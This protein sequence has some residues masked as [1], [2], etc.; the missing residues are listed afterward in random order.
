MLASRQ[1]SVIRFG[2]FEANLHSGEL[3]EQGRT[4]RVQPQ[5]MKVLAVLLERPG[6]LVTRD[7][8]RSQLWPDELYV[9]FERGLNRSINKL[10]Y[11]L[12]DNADAP[13]YIETITKRGYRFIAPVLVESERD[14]GSRPVPSVAQLAEVPTGPHWR[15]RLILWSAFAAIPVLLLISAW[16]PYHRPAAA[17]SVNHALKPVPLVTFGNGEQ[18]LP[19]F[20]PDGTRIAY[21][22]STSTGWY[23]EIKDVSLDTHARLTQR[24]ATFPPGPTWSPDGRQ[25]AFARAGVAD[26]RGVFVIS[27]IGG[28]ERKLRT[29]APWWVPERV[30]SW[31]PD[32]RWIAFADE[33]RADSDAKLNRRGPNAIYL[34]S[35]NTLETRQLTEPLSGDYGDSAPTFSPDGT[36]IAFVRTKSTSHDEI[37]TVPVNGGPP[38]LLVTTGLWT[39]GL[40]WTPD[41]KSIIFDRS[42]AGGF[43]LWRI[44]SSGSNMHPLDVPCEFTCLEPTLWGDHLA[45]ES[46]IWERT[47][48]RVA[49][50]RSHSDSAVTPYTSTRHEW[51]GRYSPDG[52][53]IAFISDRTGNDELWM[54]DAEGS[55]PIQLTG[56]NTPL[57]DLSWNS[58]GNSIAVSA[59]SGKVFLVS[60][61]THSVRLLFS[62]QPFTDEGART[63]AFSR[64]GNFF[65]VLSEPGTGESYDLL[66][67]SLADGLASKVAEGKIWN[68]AET[69][70][71]KTLF[72]SRT[73]GLW[74]RP[75]EEGAE[76]LVAPP[77]IGPWDIG[78]DGLYLLT[79]GAIERF[80]F[81]GTRRE[82]VAKLPQFSPHSPLSISPGGTAALVG[83]TQRQTVEIDVVQGFQ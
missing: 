60:V 43:R 36:T 23:L 39:N 59:Y 30:V 25:I 26:D 62:G 81:D 37:Y 32:G 78:P 11:A 61:A 40:T 46:H 28:P 52:Q 58:T 2:P 42:Q 83:Y 65:Y 13:A 12:L 44:S 73:D 82:S 70:D 22:M 64:N 35:P 55:N 33:V 7:E 34:I 56:L 80:G 71:G 48:A 50:D 27:A 57:V 51:A 15:R 69:T 77:G 41:G 38:R 45:Y 54:A 79:G 19:A 6:D 76:R 17:S 63:I 67:V 68:F 20:S 14:S 49:L 8:L 72:Y 75:V 21:S 18:W 31:S 47:I 1:G 16:P 74:K 9:D 4:I 66:K 24:A 53:Y 3:R 29:L 10:R 5:P